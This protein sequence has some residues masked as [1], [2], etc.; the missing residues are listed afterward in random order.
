MINLFQFLVDVVSWLFPEFRFEWLVEEM[1]KNLPL[2][3][4]FV[5]EGKNC[6]RLG[7]LLKD[8]PYLKVSNFRLQSGGIFNFD[9]TCIKLFEYSSPVLQILCCP[10]VPSPT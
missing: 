4:D 1:K 8:F 3:L 2:E 5:H 9:F 7:R 10:H 6:E